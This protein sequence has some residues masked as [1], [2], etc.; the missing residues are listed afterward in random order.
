MEE[1]SWGEKFEQ[2]DEENFDQAQL[3]EI[4]LSICNK[5]YFSK[6]LPYLPAG[7][8]VV[9]SPDLSQTFTTYSDTIEIWKIRIGKTYLVLSDKFD[10]KGNSQGK[11]KLSGK[12]EEFS[13][14]RCNLLTPLE[15][16]NKKRRL[17]RKNKKGG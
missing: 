6:N 16:R 14:Y 4:R 5:R 8:K 1:R 15:Y 3:E 13:T 11:V 2:D 17:Q 7:T 12:N 10:D 9:Y